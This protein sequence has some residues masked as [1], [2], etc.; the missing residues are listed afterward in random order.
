MQ[1]QTI[2]RLVMSTTATVRI[3]GIDPEDDNPPH[4]ASWRASRIP[5]LSA[6]SRVTS[7]CS[8]SREYPPSLCVLIG[9]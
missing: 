3:D 9:E 4:Q 6:K 7:N 2:V 5:G 1:D 8:Y